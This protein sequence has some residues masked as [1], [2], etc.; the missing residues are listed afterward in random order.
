MDVILLYC[1]YQHAS[2]THVAIFRVVRKT[3]HLYVIKVR[4]NHWSDLEVF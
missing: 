4:L 1:G 3:T 2:T